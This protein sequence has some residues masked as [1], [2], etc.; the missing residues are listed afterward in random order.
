MLIIPRLERQRQKDL[1]KFEASLLY[2]VISCLSR[3]TE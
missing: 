2:L 3:A 1:C